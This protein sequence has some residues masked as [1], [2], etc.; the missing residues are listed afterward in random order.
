MS[1]NYQK[2]YCIEKC[3]NKISYVNWLYGKK[4]CSHC[5]KIG[6]LSPVYKGYNELFTKKQ[7]EQEYKDKTVYDIAKKYNIPQTCMYR[8]FEKL[9]IKRRRNEKIYY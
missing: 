9:N 2:Y 4:R 8:I 6:E 5:A 3:G 7:L 1:N